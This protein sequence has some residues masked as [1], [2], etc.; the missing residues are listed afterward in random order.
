MAQETTTL[1]GNIFT[2]L[3]PVYNEEATIIELLDR[4]K[5]VKLVYG[6]NKQLVIVNDGSNDKT[7]D[8]VLDYQKKNLHHDI[9]YISHAKNRGKGAAIQ[10]GLKHASGKFLIIQDAD[11]EYD[12]KD[13][14]NLLEPLVENKADV[15]FGSR[16]LGGNLRKV[17]RYWQSMANKYL[18]TV[19]NMLGNLN[20]T[21]VGCGYKTFKT[22]MLREMQLKENGFGFEMEA[23]AKIAKMKHLRV[24]ELAVSYHSRTYDDGKKSGWK[25]GFNMLWCALKYNIGK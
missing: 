10:T 17:M 2:I 19:S 22:E 16:F 11:L 4:I 9:L 5:R 23:V 13:Y 7:A 3:I 1:D 18:T 20:L 12:P 24:C 15:V 6:M 14:N 21:D 8:L 25:D